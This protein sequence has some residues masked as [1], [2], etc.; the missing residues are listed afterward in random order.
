MKKNKKILIITS[1]I[2]LLVAAIAIASILYVNSQ[3]GENQEEGKSLLNDLYSNLEEKEKY[4][5]SA[6][7]DEN[8][9]IEYAKNGNEAYIYEKNEYMESKK[10][11]KDGNTYLLVDSNKAVYTYQNNESELNKILLQIEEIKDKEFVTGKEKIDKKEYTYQE[12]KDTTEFMLATLDEIQE[13]K[14]IFYFNK[15]KLVYIKNISGDYEELLKI[16]IKDKV[17]SNLFNIPNDYEKK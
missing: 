10:I 2:I 1:I 11:V 3:K 13:T 4:S 17:D 5:F 8:N 9:K 16:E 12:Y 6:T 7:L 14:T 15:N